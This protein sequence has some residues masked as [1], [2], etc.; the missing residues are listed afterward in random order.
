MTAGLLQRSAEV[1]FILRRRQ[2]YAKTSLGGSAISASFANHFLT[3][4]TDNH[5]S[6]TIALHADSHL[7]V[8][9][10]ER[11][12]T[13][14]RRVRL[15]EDRAKIDSVIAAVKENRSRLTTPTAFSP[16]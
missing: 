16:D 13:L 11:R 14:T 8:R 1:A 2:E 9:L 10:K 6:V 7:R 5:A 4:R 12:G 3:W 15:G